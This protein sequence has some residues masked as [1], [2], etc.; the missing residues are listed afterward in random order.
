MCVCV[1]SLLVTFSWL[2]ACCWLLRLFPLL[3]DTPAIGP[4]V[5]LSDCLQDDDYNQL[6]KAVH[7]GLPPVNKSHRVVVSGVAGL[8]AARLLQDAGHQVDEAEGPLGWRR[9]GWSLW[10]LKEFSFRK[11]QVTFSPLFIY[12]FSREQGHR[13]RGQRVSGCVETTGTDRKAGMS[14]HHEDPQLPSVSWIHFHSECRRQA[15]V[16][17]LDAWRGKIRQI[18]WFIVYGQTFIQQSSRGTRGTGAVSSLEDSSAR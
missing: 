10:A 13:L 5:C 17:L 2:L 14:V 11:A 3:G 9:G 1:S 16:L 6:L 4:G 8:I 18:I 7:T 12:F 15:S